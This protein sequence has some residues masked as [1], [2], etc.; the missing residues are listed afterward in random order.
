[1]TGELRNIFGTASGALQGI[2]QQMNNAAETGEQGFTRSLDGRLRTVRERSQTLADALSAAQQ[3]PRPQTGLE[4]IATAY[5]NWLT[6]GGLDSLLQNI[7]QHFQATPT[8]GAA[9]A[10]SIPG[11][12]VTEA[13]ADL[14]RATV[15]I[16]AVTIELEPPPPPPANGPTAA[17]TPTTPRVD[18]LVEAVLEHLHDLDVRGFRPGQGFPFA[19]T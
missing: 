7:T 9:G 13:A 3:A 16:E 4:R 15:A 10:R 18:E 19:A 8:S 1:V 5:E 6:G 12:I 17:L 2:A 11:Q 14:A